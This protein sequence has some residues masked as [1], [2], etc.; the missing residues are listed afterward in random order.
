[1]DTPLRLLVMTLMLALAVGEA[2]AAGTSLYVSPTGRDDWSGKLASPN[3]AKTDGPFATL[4]RARDAIR[5]LKT[6]GGLPKGGA[7]V[8]VADGTYPQAQ[9][10]QFVAGDSGTADSPVVYRAGGKARPRLTGGRSLPAEAF[11]PLADQAV[12]ARLT[13]EARAHVLA[14]DLKALGVTD[15]GQFPA[16]YRGA[17]AVPELF[18]N[19]V[20]M[21]LA[22][23]PNQG[24][25]TIAQIIESG[26]IP[27]TGDTGATGGVFEYT[28]DAPGRWRI[29]DGVWLQG[30]WCFDWFDE[31]IRVKALDRQTKQI[32]LA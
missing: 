4:S 10:L 27:R 16:R 31:T 6:K 19:D 13:P 17:P 18:C 22:R 24:W 20:R 30:Y 5:D 2:G 25:T 29:E 9:S 28:G 11:A 32:T 8:L 7:T 21:T 15:L 14:A 23:W 3:R 12:L 1:M 26:S